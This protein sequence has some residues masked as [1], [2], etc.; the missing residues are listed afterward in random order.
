MFV[1]GV[2]DDC[3][4][5]YLLIVLALLHQ[6]PSSS[7]PFSWPQYGRASSRTCTT[8]SNT[9]GGWNTSTKRTL[10]NQKHP[11]SISDTWDEIRSDEMRWNAL[12][13]SGYRWCIFESQIHSATSLVVLFALTKQPFNRLWR[14]DGLMD[15]FDAHLT[16][17]LVRAAASSSPLG[18]IDIGI[19]SGA[20]IQDEC[21]HKF[22]TC[23][24]TETRVCVHG[25][26]RPT[27]AEG[28]KT[29][30][31]RGRS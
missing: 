28:N 3:V 2:I 18:K 13:E 30:F 5:S 10:A 4:V 21:L 6:P 29:P 15:E 17:H 25:T 26:R 31:L 23:K 11:I 27:E 24:I 14:L 20:S 16:A 1:A 19:R 22:L 12:P 9:R 7:L 8:R